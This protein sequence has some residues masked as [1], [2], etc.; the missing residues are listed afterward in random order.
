MC[1]QKSLWDKC[2]E[3]HGHAC[4]VLALGYRVGEFAMNKFKLH[5]SEDEE[6][7]CVTENDAC[8]VDAIQ[9]TTGCTIGKGNLIYRDR[10]KLAFSFFNRKT[11]ERMRIIFKKRINWM[12]TDREEI[13]K[14]ILK[15]SFDELFDVK[16]PIFDVPE[17]ARI[18]QSYD[19]EICGERTAESRVKLQE[20]KKV[21]MDC[22]K[23]Y[24]R[25][26]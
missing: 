12:E 26:W 17:K 22:N 19:C 9:V 5:Y 24:T 1:M 15:A 7:V 11:G 25:G 3:L 21:C 13:Q 2:I 16:E 6:I 23:E 20:G 14:Y 4:P 18:F 8:C 10:G